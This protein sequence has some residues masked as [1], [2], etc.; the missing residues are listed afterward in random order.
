MQPRQPPSRNLSEFMIM[1][2]WS[3]L[4]SLNLTSAT[5]LSNGDYT[6]P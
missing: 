5:L 3:P 4:H 1:F 6:I 2:V